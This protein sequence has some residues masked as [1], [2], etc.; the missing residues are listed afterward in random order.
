MRR[1]LGILVAA[2]LVAVAAV[3]GEGWPAFAGPTGQG[4]VRGGGLPLEWD[5]TRNVVWKQPIPGKGWSSPVVD[6]GRV[7]LTTSVAVAD[8]P[9]RDQSLRALCLDARTG[10]VRWDR[11]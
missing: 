8:S 4:I 6:A 9:S 2:V 11:E 3:R 1:G 5:R 10:Q 7:Y